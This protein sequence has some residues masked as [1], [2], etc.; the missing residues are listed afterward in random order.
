MLRVSLVARPGQRGPAPSIVFGKRSISMTLRVLVFFMSLVAGT[1]GMAERLPV[2]ASIG[3]LYSESDTTLSTD[4]PAPGSIE[5]SEIPLDGLPIDDDDTGW[6]ASLGYQITSWFAL[7]IGYMDL[8]TVEPEGFPF[9][10]GREPI[11]I[12]SPIPPGP[13]LEST[14]FTLAGQFQYPLTQ[15]L[16]ATWHLGIAD[17]EFEAKGA[18]L[19]P[20][21]TPAPPFFG[22]DPGTPFFPGGPGV[23]GGPIFVDADAVPYADPDGEIGYF[24]GFG[25]SWELSPHFDI[26]ASY[27][28]RDLDVLEYDSFGVRLI[29]R[30]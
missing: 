30:L 21:L 23:P 17:A 16:H 1:S 18:R 19:A 12:A 20:V 4:R 29:G 14:A 3:G 10:L 6:S 26:E 11:G 9:L 5:H 8:G 25:L 28:R 2:Y 24:F 13:A 15:R 22:I 7:E 27:S